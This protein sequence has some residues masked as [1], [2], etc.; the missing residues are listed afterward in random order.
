[1]RPSS[2]IAVEL[3]LNRRVSSFTGQAATPPNPTVASILLIIQID[4]YLNICHARSA[5]GDKG[6]SDDWQP[7]TGATKNGNNKRPLESELQLGR[8]RTRGSV[9]YQLTCSSCFADRMLHVTVKRIVCSTCVRSYHREL[10][11]F[12]QD[13]NGRLRPRHLSTD[14]GNTYR[15]HPFERE[16]EGTKQ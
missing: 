5:T 4:S 11:P 8:K 3:V 16:R 2:T 14:L 6:Q 7:I 1:M 10:F 9:S 13:E 15:R 12:Q